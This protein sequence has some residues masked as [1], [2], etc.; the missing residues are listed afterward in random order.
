MNPDQAERI[1]QRIGTLI[2]VV[3]YSGI[4]MAV[5]GMLFLVISVV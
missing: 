1:D 5:M 4:A 3:G 2:V